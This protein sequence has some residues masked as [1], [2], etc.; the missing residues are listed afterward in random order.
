ML[1]SR[2]PGFRL[3]VLGNIRCHFALRALASPTN[4]PYITMIDHKEDIF[5]PFMMAAVSPKSDM[6]PQGR[7]LQDLCEATGPMPHRARIADGDRN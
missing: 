7:L 5:Q 4:P 3:P 6:F 2:Q 1:H